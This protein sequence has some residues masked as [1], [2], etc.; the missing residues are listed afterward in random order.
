M[1]IFFATDVHGSEVC[2]RKFLNSGAHYKADVIILGGDMTGKAL[3]P[4]IDDGGGSWH[5]TLLEHRQTLV[6]EEQVAAFEEA[7]IRRG[8]YPFRVDPDE[9]RELSED[10]PR[11]HALFEDK[12]LA[13]V[14][15]WMELADEKL[16]GTGI[17]CFVCPGNDDQLDVDK[18]IAEANTVELGEGRV[19]E[20]GGYEM[21]SSGWANR[22]PWDTYREEDEPQLAERI[23]AM[24]S[25]VTAAPERTIFSLH[26]PPY[27]TGLDDA[28]ELTKDMDLKDA[29]H[30]VR[31]VGSTAVRDAIE[32]F[33]PALSLHGHIHEARAT[34]RLGRT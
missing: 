31:P 32:S 13:T 3:V 9:L 7:V 18:V 21:V 19:L 12:M 23:S 33:Q 4:I 26:C 2:W 10:E 1:R 24:V 22:T 25:Q 20:I 28:P 16:A 14:Q 6:G 15:Q 30:A 11:W 34:K 29:G 27:N 5:A 8:Y 17:R